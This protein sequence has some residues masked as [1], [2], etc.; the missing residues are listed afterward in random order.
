MHEAEICFHNMSKSIYKVHEEEK[1]R[2]NKFHEHKSARNDSF[3]NKISGHNK[4][5]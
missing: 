2:C 1:S 3:M 4:V 5:N